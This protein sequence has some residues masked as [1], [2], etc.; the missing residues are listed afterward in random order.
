MKL[1]IFD[2]WALTVQSTGTEVT[3]TL[4]VQGTI[5]SGHLTATSRYQDW[6]DRSVAI[7][8][9]MGNGGQENTAEPPTADERARI[10]VLWDDEHGEAGFTE[11][12][13]A[14]LCLRN[15]TIMSPIGPFTHAFLLIDADTVSAFTLGAAT[16]PL[17][18]ADGEG[19]GEGLAA[20]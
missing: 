9:A 13:P 10:A 5:I 6:E 11:W 19:I 20:T 2:R 14:V 16:V 18:N 12:S 8:F 1:R 4:V 3:C 15:A 17:S 7:T